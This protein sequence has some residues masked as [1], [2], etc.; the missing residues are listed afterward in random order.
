MAWGIHA[1]FRRTLVLSKSMVVSRA[2]AKR[3]FQSR[4]MLN[5]Y[6]MEHTT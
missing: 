2:Q 1:R 5:E 6:V 4:S 3:E